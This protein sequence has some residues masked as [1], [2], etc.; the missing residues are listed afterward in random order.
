MSCKILIVSTLSI[1]LLFA[2]AA[3]AAATPQHDHV[4]VVDQ[5][6]TEVPI[7]GN[8]EVVS[9]THQNISLPVNGSVM[10]IPPDPAF[11]EKFSSDGTYQDP[12]G[13]LWTK[14]N[15]VLT[16]GEHPLILEHVDTSV[17]PNVLYAVWKENDDGTYLEE[18]SQYPFDASNDIVYVYHKQ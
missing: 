8:W 16:D 12:T 14:V 5:T 7:A 11:V 2:I 17:T 15:V 3:C 4:W 6:G 9:A 18:Y 13:A 1:I 10:A